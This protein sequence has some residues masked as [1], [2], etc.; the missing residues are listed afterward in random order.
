MSYFLEGW[1]NQRAADLH[2]EI[3]GYP[4]DR[5]PKIPSYVQAQ[6]DVVLHY[7]LRMSPYATGVQYIA[8]ERLA[9]R[10][11]GGLPLS[12]SLPFFCRDGFRNCV[13]TASVFVS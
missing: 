8:L 5:N 11:Q 4:Y 2:K 6:V 7:P 9:P 3:M 1:D 12:Y 13:V 10:A